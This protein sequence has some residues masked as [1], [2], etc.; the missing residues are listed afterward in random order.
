[1]HGEEIRVAAQIH[2]LGGFSAHGDQADLLRWHQA[3]QGKPRTWLVHGE[4]MGAE[5]LRDALAKLG[6]EVHVAKP[7]ERVEL[8]PGRTQAG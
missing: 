3:L 1:M 5:G 7:R 4:A 2:T 8:V 6:V